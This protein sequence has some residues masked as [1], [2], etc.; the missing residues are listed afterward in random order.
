VIQNRLAILT[1]GAVLCASQL[2]VPVRAGTSDELHPFTHMAL[3]PAGADLNSIRFVSAKMVKVPTGMRY[4]TN[5]DTCAALAYRD[6]G[7]SMY[8]DFAMPA[9]PVEAYQVTYSYRG[10]PLASDEYGNRSFQFEVFF[11]PEELPPALRNALAAGKLSRTQIAEDFTV[12]TSLEPVERTVI[13]NRRSSFCNAIVK[14]GL[15]K[16]TDPNCRDQVSY[17][18]SAVEPDYITVQVQPVR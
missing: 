12:K 18:T 7:G 5:A 2:S 1:L 8:C 11:R 3:I 16:L 15:W 9:S 14:D 17:K 13:D 6:P 10:Q 4:I